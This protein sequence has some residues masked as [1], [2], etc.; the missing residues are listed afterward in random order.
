MLYQIRTKFADHR[1]SVT[2]TPQDLAP[3]AAMGAA[4]AT[5]ARLFLAAALLASCLSLKLDTSKMKNFG[6]A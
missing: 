5:A 2:S 6:H 3:P 4:P 1:A